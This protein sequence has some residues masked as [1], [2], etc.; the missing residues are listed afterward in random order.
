MC[1]DTLA[2]FFD[3]EPTTSSALV[4]ATRA[5]ATVQIVEGFCDGAGI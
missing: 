2:K 4:V 5:G 1:S 3:E